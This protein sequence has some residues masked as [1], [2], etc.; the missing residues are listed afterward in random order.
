[1]RELASREHPQR[2]GG[3]ITR[4]CRRRLGWLGR[5]AG[6]GTGGGERSGRPRHGGPV[7]GSCPGGGPPEHAQR[8]SR[9]LRCCERSRYVLA[10]S[11]SV[12]RASTV[13]P[14]FVTA[15]AL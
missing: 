4:R 7:H 15:W 6:A 1:V 5:L 11:S 3:S 10:R 8:P 13:A 9:S 14:M 2:G 12:R